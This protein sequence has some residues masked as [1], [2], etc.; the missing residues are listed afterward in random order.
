MMALISITLV[1]CALV[2]SDGVTAS[3]RTGALPSLAVVVDTDMHPDDWLALLYLAS[4]PGV[5]DPGG[6]GRPWRCRRMR[7][8][9][10]DRP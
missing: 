6:D 8:R 1:S 2:E 9:G 10:R 7:G 4:E 5:D 3:I